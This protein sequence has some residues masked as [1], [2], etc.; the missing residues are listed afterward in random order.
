MT[1]RAPH[2]QLRLLQLYATF[3]YPFAC[4]PF[5]FFYFRDHGVS[6]AQYSVMI[7]VYYVTMVV[8][9]VPTGVLADR[10]G[11]KLAM[12]AGP[13]LLAAG[14]A[15]LWAWHSFTAFCVGEAVFGIGHAILSGPPSALLY[16][17]LDELGQRETFLTQES[18]MQGLRLTGTAVS[19]LAGGVC[20][21][22]FGIGTAILL[23]SALCAMAAATAVLIRDVPRRT[24]RHTRLL[25]AAGRDLR[26][27]A[28][29]WV[30]GYF[31]LV[32]CLLRYCFHTYQPFLAEAREEGPLL[33]GVLFCA[34]N[35]VAARCSRL[36]PSLTRR[37]GQPALFWSTPLILC[38]SLL[39][40]GGFVERAG[41]AIFFVQQVPFGLHWALVQSFVNH[42]IQ[43]EARATVLSVVSFVSRLAFAA[44][45]ALVGLVHDA[46]GVGTAYLLVGSGGLLA[47]VICMWPARRLVR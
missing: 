10:H 2:N 42:R 23:T 18:R 22:L 15:I 24:P 43:G 11:K 26:S 47:T 6:V 20:T 46:H 34:M 27:P 37:F 1:V 7:S 39:L 35:V 21:H 31:V 45:F 25:A 36:V 29:F 17:K 12:V 44:L 28:V 32:F 19:F 33:I 13:L 40:L 8:A 3:T 41:L 30:M 16:D 5:L 9:E 38:G 4:V 14:F